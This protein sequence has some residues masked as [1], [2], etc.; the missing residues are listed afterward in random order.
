MTA[1]NIAYLISIVIDI[2]VVVL[3]I[4]QLQL[5]TDTHHKINFSTGRDVNHDLSVVSSTL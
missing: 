5:Q 1:I 4:D 3:H 2:I